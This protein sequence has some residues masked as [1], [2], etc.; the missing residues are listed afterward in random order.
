ML[1]SCR[2]YLLVPLCATCTDLDFRG[3]SQYQQKNRTCW[4][5]FHAHY[6]NDLDEISGH[7]EVC[8]TEHLLGFV[9]LV[10]LHHSC[11]IFCSKWCMNLQRHAPDIYTWLEAD[12]GLWWSPYHWVIDWLEV[13]GWTGEGQWSDKCITKS[14][15]QVNADLQANNQLAKGYADRPII[16][17]SVSIFY[18]W[19]NLLYHISAVKLLLN[20]N[21]Q[22]SR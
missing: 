16:N 17:E 15:W 11:I 19:F 7:V 3:R 20:Q 21:F 9:F 5:H 6:P 2:H 12:E 22:V 14:D 8:Q 13:F 10:N 18:A 4:I 1:I